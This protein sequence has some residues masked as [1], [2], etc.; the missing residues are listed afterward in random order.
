MGCIKAIYKR[1]KRE[2]IESPK[3]NNSYKH[4]IYQ[5]AMADEEHYPPKEIANMCVSIDNYRQQMDMTQEKLNH[6][7]NFFHINFKYTK[8]IFE[9]RF[10][11]YQTEVPQNVRKILEETFSPFS[12][13]NAKSILSRLDEKIKGQ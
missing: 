13:S 12:D 10:N 5:I 7:V 4:N 3:H 9:Y 8:Q 1:L 11:R 6:P 2:K